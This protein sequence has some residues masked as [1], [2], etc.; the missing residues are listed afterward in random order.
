MVDPVTKRWT[1]RPNDIE[2]TALD[3]WNACHADPLL[4]TIGARFIKRSI[5]VH[6]E[7]YL[8]I[9]SRGKSAPEWSLRR[10]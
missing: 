4:D 6:I 1:G 7:L 8:F 10:P 3:L 5:M 9:P 2:V